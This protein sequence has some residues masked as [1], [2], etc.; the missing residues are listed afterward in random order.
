VSKVKTKKLRQLA[1]K[2]YDPAIPEHT[3]RKIYKQLKNFYK[4]GYLPKDL[5]FEG[6]E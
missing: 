1:G 2:L 6:A 4:S 5:K 3:R